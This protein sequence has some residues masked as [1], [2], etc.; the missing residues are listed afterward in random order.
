[1]TATAS[2]MRRHASTWAVDETALKT[3]WDSEKL[4]VDG[5]ALIFSGAC[6]FSS[7]NETSTSRI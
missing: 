2:A 6:G 7:G 4:T 5:S 3:E 1:M